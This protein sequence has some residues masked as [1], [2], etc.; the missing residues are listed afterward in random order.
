MRRKNNLHLILLS[1]LLKLI[2]FTAMEI[3]LSSEKHNISSYKTFKCVD[4]II[5]CSNQG[6][7]EPDRKDCV[8][9]QGYSTFFQNFTDYFT[10]I[11]RCNYRK[12]RQ[13]YALVLACFISFGVSH[14]YLENYLIGYLQFGLFSLIFMINCTLIIKLSFKHLKTNTASQ[15]SSTVIQVIVISFLSFVFI[16]WYIID[17]VMLVIN[18][19]RDANNQELTLIL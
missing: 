2:Y 6:S 4:P 7:C 13:L 12:K 19:Y 15:I 8:C 16:L 11:P 9:F 17:I 3:H 5:D 18:V 14:F 1:F 10:Q